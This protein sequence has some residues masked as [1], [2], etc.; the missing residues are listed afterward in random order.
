MHSDGIVE[1]SVLGFLWVFKNS[2]AFWGSVS[3]THN[4]ENKTGPF[5][6]GFQY[7][8]LGSKGILIR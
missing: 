3:R 5:I 7:L 8:N 6:F 1:A 2:F 4:Y